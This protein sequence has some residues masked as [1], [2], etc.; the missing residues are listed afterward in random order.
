MANCRDFCLALKVSNARSYSKKNMR[1]FH[2]SIFSMVSSIAIAQIQFFG[3]TQTFEKRINIIYNENNY[4]NVKVGDTLY[5][6]DVS[7]IH[8]FIVKRISKDSVDFF[9]FIGGEEYQENG[10]SLSYFNKRVIANYVDTMPNGS[11]LL[12]REIGTF[13]AKNNFLICIRLPSR[14][15]RINYLKENE[16]SVGGYHYNFIDGVAKFEGKEISIQSFL[17]LTIVNKKRSSKLTVVEHPVDSMKYFLVYLDEV[18]VA[19]IFEGITKE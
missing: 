14:I 12:S 7:A 6:L 13:F 5:L 17:K 11:Y 1:G 19:K 16:I 9:N 3:L 2:I 8:R 18:L 15:N 10:K 4:G